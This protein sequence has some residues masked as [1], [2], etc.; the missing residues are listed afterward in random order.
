VPALRGQC[1]A[2]AVEQV[3]GISTAAA[4]GWRLRA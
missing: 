1:R 3:T 2:R 4:P